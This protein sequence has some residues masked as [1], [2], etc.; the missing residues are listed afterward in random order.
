[1]SPAEAAGA[2]VEAARRR[3]AAGEAEAELEDLWR[4]FAIDEASDAVAEAL[5]AA[6]EAR[7]RSGA[8]DEARRAHARAVETT[9]PDAVLSRRRRAPAPKGEIP[10]APSR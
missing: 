4:A 6:L 9:D 5:A 10:G 7:G 1:M 8:A 2:Y 3:A